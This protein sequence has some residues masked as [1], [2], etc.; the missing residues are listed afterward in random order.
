MTGGGNTTRM[1]NSLA[2]L[3]VFAVMTAV[4]LDYTVAQGLDKHSNRGYMLL[5]VLSCSQHQCHC[6]AVPRG[7]HSAKHVTAHNHALQASTPAL[8]SRVTS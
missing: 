6:T 5:G 8:Q 3:L 7:C 1:S 2:A 4:M